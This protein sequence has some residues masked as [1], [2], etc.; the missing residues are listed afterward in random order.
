MNKTIITVKHAMKYENDVR[1]TKVPWSAGLLD[2]FY[3]KT[4]SIG[5]LLLGYFTSF[6]AC[7]QY[8]LIEDMIAV[9]SMVNLS[10][11]IGL[12]LGFRV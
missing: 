11:R 4:R 6:L 10:A 3:Y 12:G 8:V 7:G 1:Q 9:K 2:S 5:N